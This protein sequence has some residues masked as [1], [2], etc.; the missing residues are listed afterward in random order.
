MGI[1]T[2]NSAVSLSLPPRDRLSHAY[3]LISPAENKAEP[4][5]RLAAHMLCTEKG[6]SSIFC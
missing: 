3:I 4:A 1:Q 6:A 5:F 2:E